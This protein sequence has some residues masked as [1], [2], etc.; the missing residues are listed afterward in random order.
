V[1][2]SAYLDGLHM[3]ARRELSTRQLRERLIDREHDRADVDRAIEH[4]LEAGSL[5][6]ARMARAYVQTALKVK[7]R[8]RLRIQ[9]ELQQMGIEKDVAA[10]ALAAA[11]GEVDER[12]LVRNA[13]QKKLRGQTTLDTPA[14]YA[15]LYAFLVRQGFAP[16]V[17]SAAL[18]QYRRGGDED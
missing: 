8:G 9:R 6:D 14:E 5:D 10:E 7:G 12:S 11:F 18:R 1:D 15:R 3:L 17:V 2:R 13:L 16:A 4:L